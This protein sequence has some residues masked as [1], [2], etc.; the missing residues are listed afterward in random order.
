MTTAISVAREFSRHPGPRYRHH[1][2][3][4]GEAFRDDH[5]IPAMKENGERGDRTRINL[6]GTAYGYPVG[7]LEEVF[8]GAVRALGPEAVRQIQFV[9][10]DERTRNEIDELIRDARQRAE[11]ATK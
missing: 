3:G 6:E 11:T 1:N 8:G 7:W 9:G 2:D 10:A 5:L 4:S